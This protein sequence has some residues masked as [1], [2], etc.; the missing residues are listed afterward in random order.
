[1]TLPVLIDIEASGFG[2]GSYP[3]EIGFVGSDGALFC[4][5]VQPPPDW[6]HWD[7]QA[8][9]LHGIERALLFSHGKPVAWVAEQL[10]QRLAGQT[11]YCDGWGQDYP[12]LARLFDAADTTPAFKLEDLRKLLTESQAER[13]HS[14]VTQVRGELAM[15][16]HRASSDA[17]V[18]QIAL[19][20]V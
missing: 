15:G 17:K 20:R 18:L 4:T 1:M 14:V 3:I 11:V 16:R 2:K 8:A 7:E 5:L 19:G 13:W 6:T 12:W 9:A 10:N